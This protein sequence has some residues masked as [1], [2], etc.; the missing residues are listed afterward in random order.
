MGAHG[1]PRA[2]SGEKES[3]ESSG[4]LVRASRTGAALSRLLP[5][6]MYQR[7]PCF[8]GRFRDPRTGL[9]VRR[10]L[11]RN[12]DEAV[13]NFLRFQAEGTQLG[14]PPIG[15]SLGDVLAH[16]LAHVHRQHRD[17][18]RT[19]ENAEQAAKIIRRHL[20]PEA[21]VGKL[22]QTDFWRFRDTRSAEVSSTASAN[23]TLRYLK[24][25]LNR[26]VRDG[27][28]ER[29]P[30]RVEMLPEPPKRNRALP[31]GQVAKVLR[32]A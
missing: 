8:Y 18:P 28:I 1:S 22:G 7:G 26:A 19:I 24:A 16:Y 14:A 6:G 27:L 31:P 2:R 30:F 25:A 23:L 17:K 4:K 12:H 29:L 13:R 32:V 3:Q 9:E 21:P 15:P 20:D 5:P 10:S 11:G